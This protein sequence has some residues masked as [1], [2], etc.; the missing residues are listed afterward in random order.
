M[1]LFILFIFF[2]KKFVWMNL[3]KLIEFIRTK[4]E[5]M[6]IEDISVYSVDGKSSITK[7]IIVGTGRGE[8]HIDSS[9]DKLRSDLKIELNNNN[10][11]QIEGRVSNWLL[12]DLGDIIINL[13]TDESRNTYNIDEIWG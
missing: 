3:D 9:L 1:T 6:K 8:K 4:L 13:F 12:L 2:L 10:L 11:A 5:D 7:Y